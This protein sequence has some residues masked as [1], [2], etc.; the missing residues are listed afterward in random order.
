MLGAFYDKPKS[1]YSIK[2][3]K[4]LYE[5]NQS[6]W[7]WYNP[8]NEYLLKK[9]FE[10]NMICPCIFIK[11]T[12]FE[13]AI[14]V[15]YVDDLNL[16]GT[17]EELIK[18]ATYLKDGFEM[19]D[20]EKTKFFLGLQIEHLSNEIFVHQSIYIEKVLK[21]FYMDNAYPLSTPVV[22][23]SLDAKKDPFQPLEENEEILGLEV[24]Y[25]SA[26]GALMYL[27]NYIRL[28]I[29]FAINLLVR[30]SSTPTKDIEIWSNI[31]FAISLEQRKWDYFYSGSNSQLIGY[32][33]ASYLSD[34]L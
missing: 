11:K 28:D 1:I 12:T 34:P 20:L 5:L 4:S 26:I 31:Y 30:Y 10:N 17:Y 3:Q 6:S 33:D 29:A 9:G 32:A 25:L 18:I 21:H 8:L 24:P 19:K 27:A 14:V 15:V 2:L 23:R 13:F 22:V 7:M 16:V